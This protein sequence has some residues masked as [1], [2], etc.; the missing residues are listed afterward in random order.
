MELVRVEPQ[1]VAVVKRSTRWDTL[2]DAIRS[3]MAVDLAPVRPRQRGHN[4]FVYRPG[5]G[6]TVELGCGFEVAE[7]FDPVGEIVCDCIPGGEAAHAV[8]VGPYAELKRTWDPLLTA[9]RARGFPTHHVQ[10]ERYGDHDPDPARLR[11]DVYVL[12]RPDP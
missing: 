10:W 9:I 12:V 7:R 5:P 8:H 3:A 6:G 2:V 4:V 11:T 1:L